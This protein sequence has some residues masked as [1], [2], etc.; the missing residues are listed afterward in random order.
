MQMKVFR[1][2][3]LDIMEPIMQSITFKTEVVTIRTK[4]DKNHPL[5]IFFSFSLLIIFLQVGCSRAL[6]VIANGQSIFDC[7]LPKIHCYFFHSA[8]S[9][10]LLEGQ[11]FTPCKPST[12]SNGHSCFL[13][14]G[15]GLW[16]LYNEADFIVQ[17]FCP[18][19][20]FRTVLNLKIGQNLSEILVIKEKE[21][22]K[23]WIFP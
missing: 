11:E 18:I 20:G 2:S 21:N 10:A 1:L 9:H 16:V 13:L 4:T 23:T 17:D 22:N 12:F 14:H 19:F 5:I 7:S 15:T 3:V 6:K 8:E